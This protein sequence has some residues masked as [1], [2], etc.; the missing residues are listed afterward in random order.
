MY[1]FPGQ[2]QPVSKVLWHLQAGEG[3]PSTSWA[4]RV[5]PPGSRATSALQ[6]LCRKSSSPAQLLCD[7]HSHSDS[8]VG[9][10]GLQAGEKE[11]RDAVSCSEGQDYAHFPPAPSNL[12]VRAAL[13]GMCFSLP[14]KMN[15][16]PQTKRF[17]Q[18]WLKP[19]TA[20]MA[21]RGLEWFV[22]QKAQTERVKS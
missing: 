6:L 2:V 17:R 5:T 14:E 9:Q 22:V 16:N 10:H 1:Q 11:I 13:Q 3:S 20:L 8:R 7:P 12:S 4:K 15:E 19:H 18:L 21:L